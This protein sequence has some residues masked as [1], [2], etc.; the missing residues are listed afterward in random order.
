MSKY[1]N[2]YGRKLP[3]YQDQYGGFFDTAAELF[4]PMTAIDSYRK[5]G[6]VKVLS[7]GAQEAK[8]YSDVRDN[9]ANR[10]N[11]LRNIAKNIRK[12]RFDQSKEKTLMN[13]RDAKWVNLM[14]IS[15]TSEAAA[16]AIVGG[17]FY[18]A[19]NVYQNNNLI[20]IGDE[21]ISKSKSADDGNDQSLA[22]NTLA[23]GTDTL[24]EE[25]VNIGVNPA[26]YNVPGQI[27]KMMNKDSVGIALQKYA[28]AL[29]SADEVKF[30]Q[31]M[32]AAR[33][34]DRSPAKAAGGVLAI[35][36][37]GAILFFTAPMWMGAAS[38]V[39]T[40]AVKVGGKLATGAGKLA[41][42]GASKTG[43]MISEKAKSSAEGLYENISDK[44]SGKGA[45]ESQNQ[46]LKLQLQNK[47]LQDQIAAK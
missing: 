22:L 20:A 25:L 33:G 16:Q 38:S 15:P 7:E 13:Y 10:P 4:N 39:A 28:E 34:E 30:A 12:T 23:K 27:K 18:I 35:V 44:V 43:A 41:S 9:I 29:Q 5:K 17:M 3:K 1:L 42:K 31:A 24:N 45:L 26:W 19:G 6:V 36:V 40:G 8:D 46:R 37:G 14:S 11:V 2:Y 47:K 21:Y 32:R